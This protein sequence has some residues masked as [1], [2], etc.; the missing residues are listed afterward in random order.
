M[1]IDCGD[2]EKWARSVDQLLRRLGGTGAQ[3]GFGTAP[4]WSP[5][6]DVFEVED[7]VVVKM[8]LP[9]VS[10]GDLSIVLIDEKLVVK[11]RRRD[12]DAGRKT[13]YL[14]MEIAFGAFA[15]VVALRMPHE[16]DGIEARLA[17]GYL[18]LFIPRA[19]EQ[20]GEKIAVEIRL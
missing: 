16:R 4:I 1:A 20:T 13:H 7:G 14:Q 6:T 5:P 3:H 15:K 9:G 17:D 11:G 2:Y 10:P 12:T 19:E 8:E 18:D